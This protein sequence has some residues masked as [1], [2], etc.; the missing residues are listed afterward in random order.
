MQDIL[1]SK[2]S[3]ALPITKRTQVYH[4][5]SPRRSPLLLTAFWKQC[6]L[7]REK[8]KNWS[9]IRSLIFPY[10]GKKLTTSGTLNRL[11]T[12][13]AL[14]LRFPARYSTLTSSESLRWSFASELLHAAL[15][16]PPLCFFVSSLF[17]NKRLITSPF[18]PS[19]FF[20]MTSLTAVFVHW[21]FFAFVFLLL[22][23]CFLLKRNHASFFTLL[24]ILLVDLGCF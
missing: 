22:E 15:T 4:H 24:R 20:W 1:S 18:P 13:R 7:K 2:E 14:R 12:L 9:E 19:L 17:S 23:T 11:V 3:F 5:Y 16:S 6:P 21:V 10:G 8:K